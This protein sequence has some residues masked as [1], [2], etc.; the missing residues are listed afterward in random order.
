MTIPPAWIDAACEAE[1][2]YGCDAL[3][4]WAKESREIDAQHTPK[5][6]PLESKE[7]GH[8]RDHL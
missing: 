8:G 6:N 1:D 4:A 3:E 2:L 5:T 7:N